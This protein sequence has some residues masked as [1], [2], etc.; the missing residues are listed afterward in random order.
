[1]LRFVQCIALGVWL[2]AV[3]PAGAH[4]LD[5]YLQATRLAI[6]L[7]RVDLEIDLTPGVAVASKVVS[8]I[9]TNGDGEISSAEGEVYARQMLGSVTLSVDGLPVPIV[10]VETR[11]PQ[12]QDMSLRV[13]T[14]QLRATA[15]LPATGP[16]RHRVS[17]LNTHRPELSV[18]LVNA[19]VPAS[20]RIRI[21]DQRRD[22]AQHRLTL[23]YTIAS[24]G[25]PARTF[26]LL[27]GL[28]L[29]GR[30]LWLCRRAFDP[31]N[32]ARD[33]ALTF[34]GGIGGELRSPWQDGARPSAPPIRILSGGGVGGVLVVVELH[35]DQL[36]DAGFLHGH[37]VHRLRRLHGLLG[38]RDHDE[39]RV[40]RHLRR[41]A[42]LG[43]R[44]WLRQA[45]RPLH[46]E[47]RTGW[48]DI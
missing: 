44:C 6:G 41:E 14:I 3:P 43:G 30:L 1:M 45:A 42:G 13:G 31:Q 40:H 18:Y 27:A 34:A 32:Q 46:R 26:A 35:R 21:G 8:W 29:A 36:G 33:S 37:A 17:F 22:R 4:R 20:S 47:R 38:V 25:A 11:F 16:G 15:M 10:L 12:L 48:A 9:D 19:L 28:L 5:E 39:L 24:A 2:A 23:D 7:E